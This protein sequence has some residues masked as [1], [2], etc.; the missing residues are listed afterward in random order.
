MRARLGKLQAL[1]QRDAPTGPSG[2]LHKDA[3]RHLLAGICSALTA[4]FNSVK[5]VNFNYPGNIPDE[6]LE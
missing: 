3:A 2:P 5:T 6:T 1:S 4:S